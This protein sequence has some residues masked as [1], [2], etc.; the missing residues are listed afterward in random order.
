M[1]RLKVTV[2]AKQFD[3]Q[4]L[5]SDIDELAKERTSE[6]VRRLEKEIR[7]RL[8]KIE[9]IIPSSPSEG[10]DKDDR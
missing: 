7:D 8:Q 2:N 4:Q 9:K 6:G 10:E 1:K 5:L 3:F